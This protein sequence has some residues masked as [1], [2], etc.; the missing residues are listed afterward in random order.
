MA[1]YEA[2]TELNRCPF[3]EIAQGRLETPGIFWWDREFM[4]FLSI[5]PNTDIEQLKNLAA[6][7]KESSV[8]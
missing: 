7:L 6:A 8:K 3:C 4:A 2:K 1:Y 5:D